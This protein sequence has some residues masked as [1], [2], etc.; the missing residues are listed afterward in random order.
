MGEYYGL[1]YKKVVIDGED[2]LPLQPIS[3]QK[4]GAQFV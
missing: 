1:A 4:Q 3:S 2:F